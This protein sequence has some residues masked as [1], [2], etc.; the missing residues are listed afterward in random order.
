MQ[1]PIPKLRLISIISK[2]L[3]FLSEKFENLTATIDFNIFA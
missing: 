3:A 2:K 1:K